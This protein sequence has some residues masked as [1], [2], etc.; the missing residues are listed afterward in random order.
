MLPF[1]RHLGTKR[2]PW[3]TWK[4][5]NCSDSGSQHEKIVKDFWKLWTG[6]LN[7]LVQ[8]C[9]T[10]FVTE[11]N[12]LNQLFD[13]VPHLFHIL[14]SHIIYYLSWKLFYI[15]S[16]HHHFMYHVI[17]ILCMYYTRTGRKSNIQITSLF[18]QDILCCKFINR[19]KRRS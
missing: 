5:N 2:K 12:Q 18:S 17:F 10:I 16:V 14:V 7:W 3:S 4:R 8:F 15:V 9:W 13:L 11:G 6:I 1:V 19:G